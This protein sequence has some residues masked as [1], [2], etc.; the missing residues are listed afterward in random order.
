MPERGASIRITTHNI[1]QTIMPYV[2]VNIKQYKPTI[3]IVR[4]R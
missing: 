4:I 2:F 1:C 3:R